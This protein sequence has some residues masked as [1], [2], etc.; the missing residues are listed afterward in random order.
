MPSEIP[1]IR[2][3]QAAEI[4]GITSQGVQSLIHGRHIRVVQRHGIYLVRYDDV[5]VYKR[6]REQQ[7]TAGAAGECT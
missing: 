2:Q 6:E 3:C 5:I 1:L 7:Q 4:L